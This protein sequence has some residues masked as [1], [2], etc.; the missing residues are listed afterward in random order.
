MRGFTAARVERLVAAARTEQPGLAA[1]ELQR[2]LNQ[3][4]LGQP[5]FPP[6]PDLLHGEAL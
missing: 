6:L 2:L 4:Q 3:P 1:A 5:F